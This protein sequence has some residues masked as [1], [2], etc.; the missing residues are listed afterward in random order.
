MSKLQF[1][2]TI[3][4]VASVEQSLD[5]YRR[6]FGLEIAFAH[7]SGDY[8]ELATG[9]TRLAF[10]SLALMSELG[11]QP[12]AQS[13][14]KPSFEIAFETPDVDA[15]LEQALNAGAELVQSPESMPWGQ[16]TAY[17]KDLNGFL[18]ELCTALQ[19]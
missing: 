15:A 13:G 11:K 5:F 3:L 14:L 8:G 2:Y 9:T 19:S 16:T 7:E 4:Y 12:Q 1:K 17:V 10:S 18:V 6:A